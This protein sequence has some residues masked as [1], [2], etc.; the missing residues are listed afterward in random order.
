M[1]ILEYLEN[2]KA[3]GAITPD[4]HE[5]IA[6]IARKDRFSVFVELNALLYLGVLSLVAGIGWTIETYF[7]NLGDAVILLGLSGLFVASFHYCFSR[8]LPYSSSQVE[9]PNLI[10]DYALYLA[11]LVFAAELGYIESRFHILR[12]NSDF[13]LL[14]SA[15]LYFLAAY[16]FDNR[17]VLSLGLST[18]AGWFGLKASRFDLYS[19]D[20]LRTAGMVYS[21]IIAAGGTWLSR[22]GIKKHFLETYWHI[23]ANVLFMA[24]LS[25]VFNGGFSYLLLLLGLAVA[26]AGTGVRLRRFAFVAYGT[27]YG[28][29]GISW[30]VLHDMREF[31]AVLAYLIVSS[32]FVIAAMILIARR[33]GR[34]E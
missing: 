22:R 12:T 5:R 14:L 7:K 18:L 31:N 8:A 3:T 26:S 23:A 24:V 30:R 28:Y 32:C 29:I 34:E 25:G 1:T 4:Q 9:S 2:W 27:I 20:N 6:A 16:R 15:A 19:N 10:V 21:V 11:C 13:Y 33:F 17:L